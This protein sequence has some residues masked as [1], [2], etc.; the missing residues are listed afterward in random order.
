MKLTDSITDL[1][2]IGPRKAEAFG[3]LGLFSMHDV[4][5]H[6]PRKYR[7]YSKTSCIMGAKHG[8][9]VALELKLKSDPKLARVRRGLDITTARAFDQSG[10][11]TLA[12]Y[13]QP[14]RMKA[15]VA[16]GQDA[17]RKDDKSQHI[18]GAAGYTAGISCVC[19]PFAKAAAGYGQ[20]SP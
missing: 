2:G 11:I 16:G 1:K 14:Y 18:P 13:N 19:R 9:Y 3:K 10:E 8:D 6:F 12:W 15:V 5:Y 17:W 4:L 7:D 20:S